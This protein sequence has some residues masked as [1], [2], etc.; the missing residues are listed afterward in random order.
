MCGYYRKF[1]LRYAQTARPLYDLTSTK[2]KFEWKPEHEKAFLQLKVLLTSAPVLAQ[3]DVE[4]ARSGLRPFYIYTDASRVGVGAVLAQEQDD[5][6][7]HPIYFASK[8]LSKAE[9]NYHVTDQEGLAVVYALKKFHYFIYGVHTI[10]RTDHATLTSL[11]KRKNVSTR[12]LRW[13]L[14]IQRYD[15]T[16]EHVK[17]A[18]NCVAD[19]LSRGVVP[20]SEEVPPTHSENEKIVCVVQ[21]K[22][23]D[24]LREDKDFEPV[25]DAVENDRDVEVRLPRYEPD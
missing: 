15:L 10:V 6:F 14:E 4:K 1:V 20:L 9:R 16:I 11:F 17:G 2:V 8:P 7:L 22:W 25:I 24:E 5:G 12:V 21:G 18:A 19:A 3:P 23:L 13:A